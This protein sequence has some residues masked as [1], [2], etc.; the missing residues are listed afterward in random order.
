MLCV[1]A[2][3][4]SSQE[5]HVYVHVCVFG[6]LCAF[7]SMCVFMCV[8]RDLN[9]QGFIALKS[10]KPSTPNKSQISSVY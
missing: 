1:L 7:A 4:L 2:G 5:K 10:Q 6:C 9:I 3:F 8:W